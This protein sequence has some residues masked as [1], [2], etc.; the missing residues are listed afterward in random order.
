MQTYI[1]NTI[2]LI[3]I[4]CCTALVA[5][6][7]PRPVISSTSIGGGSSYIYDT[8]L[9]PL[10]YKGY[11]I[12]LNHER[13]VGIPRWSKDFYFQQQVK[14]NYSNG[15]NLAHNNNTMAGIITYD[16]GVIYK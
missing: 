11:N 9:S 7:E 1:R 14:L 16:G 4:F 5:Q 6:D 2:L 13:I 3:S 8:Y 12:Q 10:V 15:E